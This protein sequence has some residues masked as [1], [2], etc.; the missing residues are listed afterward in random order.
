MLLVCSLLCAAHLNAQPWSI[1]TPT[2]TDVTAT[3]NSGTLTISGTGAMMNF[4]AS[5]SNI[6]PWVGSSVTSVVIEAGVTTVGNY[7]FN[8]CSS[9][10]NVTIQDGTGTLAFG[11]SSPYAFSACPL[12]MLYLGRNISYGGT[13]TSSP[14]YGKTSLRTVTVGNNV[15]TLGNNIFVGCTV[16]SSVN[17]SGSLS[18]IGNNA[19][20]NCIALTDEVVNDIMTKITS[21][22]SSTFS[23]CTKLNSIV[24]PVSITSINSAAFNNC[25]L[26]AVTIQD[27]TT[28]LAF[29][30][31]NDQ[32]SG[33]PI[34]T[35]YLGRNISYG[36]TSTSSPFYGKTSLRTVTVGNNVNTL[37]NNI[38]VGCTVLSSVNI[39]GSL[40]SIGNNAFQNCIALTDEVVNAIMTKITSISSSTFG[41]CTKLNSIVIPAS[42]TTIN[43]SAFSNCG[44]T[45]VTIQDGTIALAF[46]SYNDQFSGCP[47]ETLY[48]GRNISYGGTST[49]SPFYGKTALETVTLGSNVTALGNYVFNGCRT[50]NSVTI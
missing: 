14:F 27:G 42:L 11:S 34:E 17:I 13:T 46:G 25:G 31:Y 49:S 22:S 43:S 5:G 37:G 12:E 33:C 45:A 23:G 50:L 28:A 1:G 35:L 20:Q 38:F 4:T 26:T 41:G 8:N 3:L 15:N 16:L 9:L 32:F 24:I 40:S 2:A 39:P 47:I 29:G 6:A 18:S 19:F 10:T 48:L 21:I 44:L 36:G 30:S 7:A